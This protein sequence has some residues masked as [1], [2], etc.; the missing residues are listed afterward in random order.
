VNAGTGRK[1]IVLL[2]RK[3]AK[4]E[5]KVPTSRCDNKGKVETQ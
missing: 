5:N 2:Q 4:R 3:I 1:A